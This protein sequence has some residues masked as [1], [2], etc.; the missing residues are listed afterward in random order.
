MISSENEFMQVARMVTEIK[1][2]IIGLISEFENPA[3][4]EREK[5]WAEVELDE[6][7]ISIAF[8]EK[9][10]VEYDKKFN[11]TRIGNWTPLY[12][13]RRIWLQDPR[14]QD[15]DLRDIA[16]ALS[17]VCRYGGHSIKKYS[18]AQHCVLGS[19][20]IDG[21]YAKY[22]LFHDAAESYLGDIITPVKRLIGPLY[23]PL[24]E[25]LMGA[26]SKKFNFSMDL[27]ATSA[28]KNI[29]L[30]ML[31]TEIRDVT[32]S[33]VLREV[34]HQPSKV[35]KIEDFWSPERAEQLFLNQASELGA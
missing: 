34:T 7:R 21:Q 1:Q 15:I 5:C 20:M 29:D 25:T 13:G 6:L 26:I 3:I 23:D 17:N 27:K 8:H 35:L 10:M 2:D 31:A 30:V 24:E 32:T 4:S 22:F 16:H 19:Q 18:V 9:A 14:P 33:K 28:V 12:S 11:S